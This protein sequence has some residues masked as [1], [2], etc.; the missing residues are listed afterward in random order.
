MNDDYYVKVA[1]DPDTIREIAKSHT[2]RPLG[3]NE[4]DDIAEYVYEA[5]QEEAD[6]I[7]DEAIK[8]RLGL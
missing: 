2:D 3:D 8:D 6:R 4:I 7:Y 5:V 1:I